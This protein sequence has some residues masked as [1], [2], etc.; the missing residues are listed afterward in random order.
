[1][2]SLMWTGVVVL[3]FVLLLIFIIA[4]S[5]KK[6]SFR[7]MQ[8]ERYRK[9]TGK[10]VGKVLNRRMIKTNARSTSGMTKW[11]YPMR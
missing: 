7:R 10:A 9:M 3:C 5:V 1:M 4:S 6:A 11:G 2:N 8:R